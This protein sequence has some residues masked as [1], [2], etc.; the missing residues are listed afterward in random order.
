ME[1]PDLARF[2]PGLGRNAPGVFE[3]NETTS[4]YTVGNLPYLHVVGV[5][6]HEWRLKA[7]SI[8]T[9]NTT[10]WTCIGIAHLVLKRA[11]S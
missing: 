7:D 1:G 9:K 3:S 11:H 5:I 2:E 10:S 8:A 6:S 4:N